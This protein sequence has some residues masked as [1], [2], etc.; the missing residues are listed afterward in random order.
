[1]PGDPALCRL[2]AARYLKLSERVEDPARR[3]SL[4]AL[5]ETW[6]KLAAELESEQALLNALS[7]L[8]FD[9]PFAWPPDG[10][11]LVVALELPFAAL[12]LLP[13][14]IFHPGPLDQ[15]VH[16]TLGEF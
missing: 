15:G 4:A 12:L 14:A 5:A 8:E 16:D 7:E 10:H 13:V 11:S 2:Y 6:T 3:R 9:E 1:M